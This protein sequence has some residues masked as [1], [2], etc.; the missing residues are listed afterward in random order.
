VVLLEGFLP[1][2]HA[3]IDGVG[4]PVMRANA[5]FVAAPTSA[6]EHRVVFTYRPWPAVL[7]IWLSGLTAL[8]LLIALTREQAGATA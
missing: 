2:W 3:T 6:G 5:L 1:G 8:A 4:V 7:G